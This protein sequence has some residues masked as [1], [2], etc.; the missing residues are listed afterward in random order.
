M[1]WNIGIIGFGNVGSGFARLLL[2]KRDYLERKYDFRYRLVGIVDI[3][4]GSAYS[5]VG[6]PLGRIMDDVFRK[7]H[8]TGAYVTEMDALSLIESGNVDLLVET[9]PTNLKNG[10]PALKYVR[11][12]LQHGIHV[13]TTN[14]GV[15]LHGYPSLQNIAE[16]R[17][18][19]WRF[20][21]TVLSGTPSLT[22]ATESLAGCRIE[23]IS[24]ILNGTTNFI[25]T[26]MEEGLS[27]NEA[28]SLAQKMGYAEQDAGMDID[29]L[30][31][32]VKGVIL[33][34]VIMNA[35]IGLK[36]VSITGIRHINRDSIEKLRRKG[37]R[38]KLLVDIYREESKVRVRVA[39]REIEMSEPLAHVMG[40]TNAILF[41]TDSLS[42]V[43]IMGP[44]AGRRE[45]GQAVL[46]DALWIHRKL[47]D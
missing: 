11:E 19:H 20:D 13:V 25:L 9:T 23:R 15:V 41:R 6:L 29:G 37:K 38:I 33:A 21:G 36:D 34:R 1:L 44:G 32:A 43:M 14:K 40:T 12:A 22:L 4:R 35:N 39:P 42:D 27:F 2:E 5:E 46:S 7:G 45:T 3:S 47:S 10:E 28:L 30:D 31:S 8:I 26:R 24:G 16:R 17:G 18:V